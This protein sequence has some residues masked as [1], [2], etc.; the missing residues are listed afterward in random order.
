[1]LAV[2]VLVFAWRYFPR[3]APWILVC[4]LLMCAG[5]VY[6]GYHYA[7]DVIAGVVVGLLVGAVGVLTTRVA[8]NR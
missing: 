8:N 1:M 6:D 4:V 7:L 2:V 5:A 3:T